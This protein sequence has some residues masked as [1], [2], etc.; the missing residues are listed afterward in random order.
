M[1]KLLLICSII[2]LSI[3]SYAGNKPLKIIYNGT[4]TL[5]EWLNYVIVEYEKAYPG[6]KVVTIPT[7]GMSGNYSTKLLMILKNDN[8]VDIVWTSPA[9]YGLA[10]SKLLAPLPKLEKWNPVED[11]YPN[12][13]DRCIIN[14]KLYGLPMMD[15]SS[16]IWYNK[17]IF[18]KAGLPVPW[19]PKNWED[20]IKAAEQ[21]KTK[22]P[23]VWPIWLSVAR[24]SNETTTNTG[25]MLLYGTESEL[26]KNGKWIVNS[27]GILNS[28]EFIQTLFKKHLTAP[29]PILID[30]NLGASMVEEYAPQ[31]KIGITFAGN[32]ISKFWTKMYNNEKARA[33]FNFTPFPTQFGQKPKFVSIGNNWNFAVSAISKNKEKALNFLKIATNKKCSEKMIELMNILIPHKG[34][35]Y[36]ANIDGEELLKYNRYSPKSVDY[37]FISMEYSNMIESI[38]LQSKTP[39]EAMDSFAQNV[40]QSLGKNKVLSK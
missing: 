19:N 38:A 29:I 31:Q 23:K 5:T 20:I 3:A 18:K 13:I 25:L 14:N 15:I 1:K 12:I 34:V 27:K 40:T 28:L 30:P 9:F 32:Y 24:G 35:K 10:G 36:P 26:Y 37:N 33:Y 11:Y 8:S 39:K 22:V 6:E 16:G 17:N 2:F 4:K 21:I 7:F